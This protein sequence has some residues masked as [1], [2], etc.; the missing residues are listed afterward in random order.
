MHLRIQKFGFWAVVIL[1]FHYVHNYWPKSILKKK[2]SNIIFKI[3]LPENLYYLL[4]NILRIKTTIIYEQ[5][6]V[7]VLQYG[8]GTLCLIFIKRTHWL[9]MVVNLTNTNVWFVWRPALEVTTPQS[10]LH[11]SFFVLS[12]KTR[13]SF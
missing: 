7:K 12:Y 11:N 2:L 3:F 9:N 5:V 10:P 13:I 4:N 1:Y 8:F 6:C